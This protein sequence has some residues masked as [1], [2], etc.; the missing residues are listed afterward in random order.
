MLDFPH[1]KINLG[2]NITR[3]RPDGYHDIETI[4]YPIPIAD[5]L[6]VLPWGEDPTSEPESGD[7]RT[8]PTV[9][10]RGKC[11][12]FRYGLR[13]EAPADSDLTVRAYSLL[14][15]AYHLPPADIHLLKRI[16]MGAGL[17]GG[18]ADAAYALKLLNQVFEIGLSIDEL[19]GIAARLGAD[20]AFFV[21]G[22]PVFAEGIGNVFTPVGHLSLAGYGIM[23]VKPDVFVSTREA[24][25]SVKPCRPTVSL[26]EIAQREPETWRELMVNDFEASIFPR[27]PE[28]ASIKQRLYDGGALYASMSGSGSSVY[29]LFGPGVETPDLDFGS[30]VFVYKGV[31]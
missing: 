7:P 28:I 25:A 30:P 16:P 23:V 17:G 1:A 9:C 11:R 24:Y 31:L 15:E 27:F 5:A 13:V 6:E 18:S 26:K 2:L 12:L 29:G 19:E 21:E 3:R 4:F 20:C 22:R 10:A 14:D 8:A